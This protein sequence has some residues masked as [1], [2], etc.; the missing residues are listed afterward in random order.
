MR[1]K[2]GRDRSVKIELGT[3]LFEFYFLILFGRL[4]PNCR[5]IPLLDLTDGFESIFS[6]RNENPLAE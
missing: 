3:L 2:K 4:T 5:S 6:S 1:R